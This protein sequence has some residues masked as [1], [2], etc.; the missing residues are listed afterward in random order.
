M[1]NITTFRNIKQEKLNIEIEELSQKHQVAADELDALLAQQDLKTNNGG[2][3]G[4]DDVKELFG[5]MG[6]LARASRE[7][8]EK[9][10]EIPGFK[11]RMEAF[12]KDEDIFEKVSNVWKGKVVPVF[13]PDD[14]LDPYF[15]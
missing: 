14:E 13:V 1:S 12:G 8:H 10:L 5:A 15:D 3:W 2:T 4:E 7:L 11:E 6:K 9:R